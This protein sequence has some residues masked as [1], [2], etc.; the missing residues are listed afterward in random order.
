MPGFHP[1]NARMV[2]TSIVIHDFDQWTNSSDTH[3]PFCT[4]R[5][6]PCP[7]QEGGQ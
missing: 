1:D 5:F 6:L 3:L 4:C 2:H 7:S